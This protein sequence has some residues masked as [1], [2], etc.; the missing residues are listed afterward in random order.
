M[1]LS[2]K[3]LRISSLGLNIHLL[4]NEIPG[5]LSPCPTK[6]D[7]F[8]MKQVTPVQILHGKTIYPPTCNIT[9]DVPT[10]FSSGFIGNIFHKFSEI[11]ISLFLTVLTLP[12]AAR[13][14]GHQLQLMVDHQIRRILDCMFDYEALNLADGSVHCF[15]GAVLG[16]R[17]HSSL[18]INSS[19]VPKGHYTRTQA[20]S[21][22]NL[23]PENKKNAITELVRKLIFKVVRT[24]PNTMS[25]L[26]NITKTVS[27]CSV[28]IG[29]HVA[30]LTKEIVLLDGAVVV[31]LVEDWASVTYYGVPTTAMIFNK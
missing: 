23:W 22:R 21:E 29:V 18:A 7:E 6:E 10:V 20:V 9:H 5:L 16:L 30:G 12:I 17:N 27:S 2:T 13:I 19:D 11:I 8:A 1:C 31:V 14:R 3:P 15:P 4:S 25:D 28:M 24:L 26:D